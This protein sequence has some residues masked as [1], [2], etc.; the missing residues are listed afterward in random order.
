MNVTAKFEPVLCAYIA[1]DY[2]ESEMLRA[3]IQAVKPIWTANLLALGPNTTI[4]VKKT[5]QGGFA[6][7]QL[8]GN[9]VD[10][11]ADAYPMF[12]GIDTNM[13]YGKVCRPSTRSRT[14]C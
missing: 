11:D 6:A 8:M 7:E 12:K 9:F 5:P 1:L 3:E 10:E 14:S 2:K 4:V 13:F